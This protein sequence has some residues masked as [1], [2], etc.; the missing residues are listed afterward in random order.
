MTQV[1]FYVGSTLLGTVT[2][3]PYAVNWDT[4]SVADGNV[5]LT[6]RAY[7]AAGNVATSATVTATVN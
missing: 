5:T 3:A 1:E 7:D 4:T 6:T 2:T